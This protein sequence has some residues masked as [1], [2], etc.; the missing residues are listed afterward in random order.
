M[1]QHSEQDLRYAAEF[2]AEIHKEALAVVRRTRP[3]ISEVVDRH[4]AEDYLQEHWD[5]PGK[6]Y[7]IVSI[8]AGFGSRKALVDAIA[9]DTLAQ[10]AAPSPPREPDRRLADRSDEKPSGC[11]ELLAVDDDP[12]YALIAAYPDCVVDYGIVAGDGR[13]SGVAS[14]RAALRTA[15]RDRLERGRDDEGW[16][17]D[18]GLAMGTPVPAAGQFSSDYEDGVLNYRRAF[19][20]PPHENRYTGVDFVRVN[21]ALFPNGTDALEACRWTTDWS[22]YF[23]EGREWWG[24]LCLTVYDKSLDR[25][26]VI[27]ASAT[28]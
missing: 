12:F 5:Y 11:R 27:L 22:D 8:P 26:V 20:Y 2:R 9:R 17:G 21:A 18:P 4:P 24:T 7:T 25:Y 6:W 1:A 14:H 3:D 16:T 13:H 23:D 28:D 10:S 19:L 15:W